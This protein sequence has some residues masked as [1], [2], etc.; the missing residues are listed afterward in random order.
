[1]RERE[2]KRESALSSEQEARK[3]RHLANLENLQNSD[4]ESFY[5][6]EMER[7][8]WEEVVD[9][10][11]LKQA[12]ESLRYIAQLIPSALYGLYRDKKG[13]HSYFVRRHDKF[14]KVREIQLDMLAAAKT[15]APWA[16]QRGL[17]YEGVKDEKEMWSGKLGTW[18]FTGTFIRTDSAIMQNLANGLGDEKYSREQKQTFLRDDISAIVHENTH[19]N[20]TDSLDF[21][22][23]ARKISE[24]AP[25]ASEYLAF[26]GKN[27]KMKVVTEKARRLL[28]DEQENEDY[29]SDATLMGMLVMACDEGLMPEEENVDKMEEGLSIWQTKVEELRPDELTEYRRKVE[30][31]WLLSLDDVKLREKLSE[32][33]K[34][35]PNLMG[36]LIGEHDLGTDL[37]VD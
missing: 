13:E 35:Y 15:I 31:E 24:A 7:H 19:I 17:V 8:E 3:Q 20:N 26:P 28:R 23:P 29:Y 30:A 11:E 4:L 2:P 32:L 6:V 10:E 9:E 34:Q 36:R 12:R 27:S 25:M 33:R 21:G 5:P 37:T 22:G 18:S 16:K 14:S 1:M